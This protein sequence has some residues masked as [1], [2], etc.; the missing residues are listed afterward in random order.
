MPTV[1]HKTKCRAGGLENVMPRARLNHMDK[2]PEARPLT[3]REAPPEGHSIIQMAKT[4]GMNHSL[5]SSVR[6]RELRWVA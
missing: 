4:G 2:S 5:S 1:T 3:E 6:E